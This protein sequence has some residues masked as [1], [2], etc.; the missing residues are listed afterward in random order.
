MRCWQP[1]GCQSFVVLLLLQPVRALVAQKFFL[2]CAIDV[3][4]LRA[5]RWCYLPVVFAPIAQNKARQ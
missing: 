2:I 5:G 1:F 3:R 4:A